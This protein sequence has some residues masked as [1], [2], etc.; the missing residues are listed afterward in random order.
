MGDIIKLLPDHISNQI[1]AGEVI[2]RPA[3]AVKELMENSVDA[4]ATH[5]RL[6]TKEAGKTLIQVIDN[7]SGMSMTDARLSFEKHATSKIRNI[8]DLFAIR[9]MGFRGEALASIAAIAQVELKTKRK[10]D[11]LATF[12]R[13][14]GSEVLEQCPGQSPDGTN[15]IV[16]NLFYNVPARRNFLKSN[17]VE[18]RHIIDEFQ[19]IAL[20][21]PAIHFSLMHNEHEVYHLRPGNLRQRIVA[22]FGEGHNAHLVPIEERSDHI[23]VYGF[24]GKPELSKKTRGEQFI[25]VN[26]RFIKSS[27][28]NHAVM[29]AYAEM[30]PKDQFPFFVLFIDI[31]PTL[32]DINVH[33]TKQEIKF[34][35][36][37]LVYTFV[38]AGIRHSLA[39]YSVSPTL[40]FEQE[41]TINNWAAFGTMQA[42]QDDE[43]NTVQ[44]Q[45]T[46]ASKSWSPHHSSL[47]KAHR[48]D[49]WEELYKIALANNDT[50]VTVPSSNTHGTLIP[51]EEGQAHRVKA[52]YQV[53]N[54]YI[55]SQIK[56]GFIVID[57]SAAHERIL[58]EKYLHSMEKNR[59][60]GQRQLFPQNLEFNAQDAELLKDI[61][62]D[63]NRLG[64]EIQYFGGNSFVVHCFP[65]DLHSG[66]EKKIIEEL[67]EQFKNNHQLVKL[68]K[69]ENLA[70]SLAHS[71]SIKSGKALEEEEMNL[72]IDELFSCENPYT[73]AGGRATFISFDFESL[74]QKFSKR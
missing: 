12:L 29:N 27:Y 58:Y 64:F 44:Q 14:E 18:M 55:I 3:S 10:E 28:L 73:T 31:N 62:E 61:L 19:R 34:E 24:V 65:A 54:R 60:T 66:Q 13:I 50:S 59:L 45:N 42:K 47:H 23:Q 36:E 25:F 51:Q 68:E 35:D 38:N 21:H 22:M 39:K 52:P 5:I 43:E 26:N 56:S 9:T 70:R 48:N 57:Q 1:A 71:S 8:D 74:E 41:S 72:L 7:G 4:G 2:Q 6:I 17:A 40:D 69:R 20:A 32:I 53:H 63:I 49:N 67:L 33:P 30:I 16:K 37:R 15:T 11:E 46:P